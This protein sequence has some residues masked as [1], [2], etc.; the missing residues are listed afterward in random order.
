MFNYFKS[1]TRYHVDKVNTIDNMFYRNGI[2]YIICKD[3]YLLKYIAKSHNISIVLHNKSLLD[4]KQIE[5][6]FDL[7]VT[8]KDNNLHVSPVLKSNVILK[9]V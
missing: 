4:I 5:L 3:L 8:I 7:F 6:L 2:N 1:I 9:E